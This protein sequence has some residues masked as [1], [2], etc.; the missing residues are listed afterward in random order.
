MSPGCRHHGGHRVP[1]KLQ[2]K[3]TFLSE[4]DGTFQP[5]KIQLGVWKLRTAL[6]R[7]EMDRA[8]NTSST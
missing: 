6:E 7:L 4:Q 5:E 2:W 8:A 1:E 3:E